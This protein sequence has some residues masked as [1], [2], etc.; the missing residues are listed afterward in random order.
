MNSDDRRKMDYIR[1]NL[2]SQIDMHILWPI[3]IKKKVFNPDD[4]NV[5]KWQTNLKDSETV[6]DILS[7]IKTR[8][9]HAYKNFIEA[10]KQSNQASI[11]EKLIYSMQGIQKVNENNQ[12]TINDDLYQNLNTCDIKVKKAERFLDGVDFEQVERYPM[13]SMQRGSVLIVTCVQSD[14]II[15]D[16]FIQD[17]KNLEKLF[18]EM[19]FEITTAEASSSSDISSKVKKFSG[20]K[21][22]RRVD[23]LFLVIL[24]CSTA[25]MGQMYKDPLSKGSYLTTDIL[26]CF[27]TK[28]CP[29]LIRK[30]KIFIFQTYD[31]NKIFRTVHRTDLDANKYSEKSNVPGPSLDDN[32]TTR[33]YEDTFIVYSS[34]SNSAVHSTNGSWFVR[35][36]CV[37]FMQQAHEK[38]I[39][40]LLRTVSKNI[41]RLKKKLNFSQEIRTVNQGFNK[42]CYLNPGLYE[43]NGNRNN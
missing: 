3:L 23:S 13:R 10:L 19:G 30:P 35:V 38:H 40:D 8:G 24:F 33:N 1:D 9:P 2:S 15:L 22:L 4:V 26:E 43:T 14:S 7:M 34:I 20:T 28:N 12:D 16:S 31:S 21:E 32:F 17:K 36:L 42:H 18:T 25:N 39:V 29:N 11:I 6:K 27:T 5:S 37:V 41:D